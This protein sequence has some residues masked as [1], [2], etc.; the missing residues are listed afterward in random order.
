[1]NDLKLESH[2]NSRQA[3]TVRRQLP[4]LGKVKNY[5]TVEFLPAAF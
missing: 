5:K 3:Q 2:F 4:N 1:M